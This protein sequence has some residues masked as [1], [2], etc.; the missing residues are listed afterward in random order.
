MMA[1]PESEYFTFDELVTRLGCTGSKLHYLIATGQIVPALYLSELETYLDGAWTGG[2]Y[3]GDI[4]GAIFTEF[5]ETF[6][7]ELGPE[8]NDRQRCSR[9]VYCH[10]PEKKGSNDYSFD[11]FSESIRGYSYD[12]VSGKGFSSGRWFPLNTTELLRDKSFGEARFIFYRDQIKHLNVEHHTEIEK[13]TQLIDVEH[14]N[15]KLHSVPVSVAVALQGITKQ[16]VIQA[17]DGIHFDHKQWSKYLASPAPWLENCRIQRGTRSKRH[18]ALWDPVLIA[19]AL[20]ETASKVPIKKL[21][22]V[23][24]GHKFLKS[25]I[26]IWREKS[27]L[28]R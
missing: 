23:F 24:V 6:P 20:T 1:L 25:W 17:F 3:V 2:S 15:G 22:T 8:D 27:D 19:L 12:S 7:D 10:Y 14:D 21:D 28:F 13:L 18:I 9:I 4:D 11:F 16:Q 26:D 5:R